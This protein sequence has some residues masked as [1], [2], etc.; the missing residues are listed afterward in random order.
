MLQAQIMD[1]PLLR[2]STTAGCC[3]LLTHLARTD[4]GARALK[5]LIDARAVC[6]VR[7]M[8]ATTSHARAAAMGTG[9]LMTAVRSWLTAL[10][11]MAPAEGEAALGLVSDLGAARDVS[12]ETHV[13]PLVPLIVPVLQSVLSGGA[14]ARDASAVAAVKLL[15]SLSAEQAGLRAVHGAGVLPLLLPLMRAGSAAGEGAYLSEGGT[16]LKRAL[17]DVE[18]RLAGVRVVEAVVG[19][20]PAAEGAGFDPFDAAEARLALRALEPA[21]TDDHCQ[22][23]LGGLAEHHNVQRGESGA[24]L[25]VRDLSTVTLEDLHER[26]GLRLPPADCTLPGAEDAIGRAALAAGK[27]LAATT[28]KPSSAVASA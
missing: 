22:R 26:L 28:A 4:A 14:S 21:L 10:D 11:S 17:A 16:L 18:A 3:T 25:P 23:L 1:D 6:A 2:R 20:L 24:W 7:K 15:A 13:L 19:M 27:V 5:A 8:V 9:G 12:T